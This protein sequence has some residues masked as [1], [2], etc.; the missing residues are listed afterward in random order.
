MKTLVTTLA[1]TFL[2]TTALQA[3]EGRINLLTLPSKAK[4]WFKTGKWKVNVSKAMFSGQ[5]SNGFPQGIGKAKV[6]YG[7][8]WTEYQGEWHKGVPHG[9]GEFRW[10]DGCLYKGDVSKGVIQGRGKMFFHDGDS[11]IGAWAKDEEHGFGTY[12]FKNGD[13]YK[14]LFKEGRFHGR[15]SFLSKS[16]QKDSGLW[17]NDI[18]I[19]KD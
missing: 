5:Q 4:S 2:G 14:G 3:G 9:V 1:L 12:F 7:H 15:G 11:Y 16:G 10:S 13:Q 18:L 19:K 17:Q 8:F 6:Q